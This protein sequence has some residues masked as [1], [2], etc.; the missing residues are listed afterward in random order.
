MST[1]IWYLLFNNEKKL[2]GTP[3]VKQAPHIGGLKVAIKEAAFSYLANVQA[4]DLVAW[5]CK[6]PL[7]STQDDDELQKHV[8]RIDFGNREQVVKLASGTRVASLGL[9]EVLLIQVPGVILNSSFFSCSQ[10]CP[11]AVTDLGSKKQKLE[12]E[13]PLTNFIKGENRNFLTV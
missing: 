8:S 10:L 13:N 12:E 5:R 3:L 7:L 1:E 6:K 2:L 11:L 4:L 9:G